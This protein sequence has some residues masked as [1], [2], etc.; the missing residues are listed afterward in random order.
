M[1]F[2]KDFTIFKVMKRLLNGYTL[3][4]PGTY[5]SMQ[6]DSRRS[7]NMSKLPEASL[8]AVIMKI[9]IYTGL[10]RQLIQAGIIQGPVKN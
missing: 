7:C 2:F 10:L 3:F 5:Y 6:V 1:N 4:A 8:V 9:F